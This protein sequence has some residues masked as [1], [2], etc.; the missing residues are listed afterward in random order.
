MLLFLPSYGIQ[1]LHN[2]SSV[3]FQHTSQSR[4]LLFPFQRQEI[5]VQ[6]FCV[7]SRSPEKTF[8]EW[9]AK[10]WLPQLLS[11]PS[12]NTCKYTFLKMRRWQ[13]TRGAPFPA[14]LSHWTGITL[15]R[16]PGREPLSGLAITWVAPVGAGR[17]WARGWGV[18]RTC[19]LGWGEQPCPAGQVLLWAPRF[20]EVSE[21]DE[22][23]VP[24]RTCL[25][26]SPPGKGI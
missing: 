5:G 6:R 21:T 26:L 3:S 10:P 15:P 11:F 4:Q 22:Q 25:G 16:R 9:Q 17:G 18:P 13:T 23:P 8:L 19:S 14:W 7:T 24:P 2:C 12:G 1:T 20:R